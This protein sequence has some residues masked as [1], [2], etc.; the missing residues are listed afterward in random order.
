MDDGK[1]PIDYMETIRLS[2]NHITSPVDQYNALVDFIE[3]SYREVYPDDRDWA[4]LSIY[5]MINYLVSSAAYE[6]KYH[7][8]LSD[9]LHHS[10]EMSSNLMR[11]IFEVTGLIEEADPAHKETREGAE[12]IRDLLETFK[13]K[14]DGEP[15]PNRKKRKPKTVIHHAIDEENY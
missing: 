2:H 7:E 15:S 9:N 13:A 5:E 10:Q 8:L 1:F 6:K 14:I 4:R 3:M 12:Q 11:S